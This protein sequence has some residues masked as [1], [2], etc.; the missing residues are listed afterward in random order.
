M[1]DILQHILNTLNNIPS[2]IWGYLITIIVS[3]VPTSWFIQLYK[4]WRG[5]KDHEKYMLLLTIAGSMVASALAYL[6]STPE[7][8]PW[9]VLVQGWLVFATTQPVYYL[10]VK[11]LTKKLGSYFSVQIAKYATVAEAKSAAVPAGG[12]VTSPA[13]VEDFAR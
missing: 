1:H 2:D 4:K 11:P 12:L 13:Q 5:I 3:A 8:A 7:F 9:F 6:H 10:F